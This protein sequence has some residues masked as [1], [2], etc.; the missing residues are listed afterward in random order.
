MLL[1]FCKTQWTLIKT[2]NDLLTSKLNFI[3]MHKSE[4]GSCWL[5]LH[6]I[7]KMEEPVNK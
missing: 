4:I 6:D 5:T 3:K 7:Q 1:I 2:V